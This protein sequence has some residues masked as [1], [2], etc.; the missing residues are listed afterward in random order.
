VLPEFKER[1]EI[2]H[3]KWRN[4]QLEGVDFPISSSV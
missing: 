3:R 2:E 1:H 4:E